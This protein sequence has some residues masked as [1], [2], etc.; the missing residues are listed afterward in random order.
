MFFL[1]GYFYD[2]T[3]ALGL[4]NRLTI[5][6]INRT[7]RY[8]CSLGKEK[9][10]EKL[11]EHYQGSRTFFQ[12]FIEAEGWNAPVYEDFS[13]SGKPRVVEAERLCAD[14]TYITVLLEHLGIKPS[15]QLVINKSVSFNGQHFG[16]SWPLGY[17]IA[18]ANG[19]LGT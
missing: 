17:S 11:T 1:N 8:A 5:N 6:K 12:N 19:W 3:V 18:W 2:R 7:A 13:N 9:T 16:L 10:S 15:H 4:P 14:L